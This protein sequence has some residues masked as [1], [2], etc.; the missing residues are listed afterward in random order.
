MVTLALIRPGLLLLWAGPCE[1]M[2]SGVINRNTNTRLIESHF[3]QTEVRPSFTQE[4]DVILLLQR[5]RRGRLLC[6]KAE[7]RSSCFLSECRNEV[8]I[9]NLD[10]D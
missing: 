5:C 4:K 1:Q 6:V 10:C 2:S 9:L 3:E 8:V 7:S